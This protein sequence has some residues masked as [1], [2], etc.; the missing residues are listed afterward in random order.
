MVCEYLD[1][2]WQMF[3]INIAHWSLVSLTSAI[4]EQIYTNNGWQSH[5]ESLTLAVASLVKCLSDSLEVLQAC[6][7]LHR[8]LTLVDSICKVCRKCVLV[9]EEKQLSCQAQNMATFPKLANCQVGTSAQ[10]FFPFQRRWNKFPSLGRSWQ[11]QSITTPRCIVM[12]LNL[13]CQIENP[14]NWSIQVESNEPFNKL[15]FE[16]PLL[17][18]FGDTP[19]CHPKLSSNSDR[20]I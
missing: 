7:L 2:D 19:T 6:L 20:T 10:C 12:S 14:W 15:D 11:G 1:D 17:Y 9:V 3:L 16:G 4:R 5:P 18:L 8:V 13:K